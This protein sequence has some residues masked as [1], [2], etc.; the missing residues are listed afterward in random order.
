MKI[1]KQMVKQR[2]KIKMHH[3]YLIKIKSICNF[4]MIIQDQIN[5]LKDF[6]KYYFNFGINKDLEKLKCKKLFSI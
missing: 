5:S 1:L 4:K 2:D 3:H 6:Q